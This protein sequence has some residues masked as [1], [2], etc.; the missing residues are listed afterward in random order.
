MTHLVS[1]FLLSKS[2]VSHVDARCLPDMPPAPVGESEFYVD[3]AP[4]AKRFAE[5]DE[6]RRDATR[7]AIQKVLSLHDSAA[8]E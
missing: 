7:E 1:H 5:T 2:N 8:A 3:V 4:L 6:A